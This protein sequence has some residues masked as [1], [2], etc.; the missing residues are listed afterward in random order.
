MK[1]STLAALAGAL[2]LAGG[3]AA[4][5]AVGDRDGRGWG[6]P[7]W[8]HG[9]EQGGRGMMRG[10]RGPVTKE[11]SEAQA[12]ERFARLDRN[13]D[14]VIDA[15]EIEAALNERMGA[16]RA[17]AGP[18]GQMFLRRFDENRDG[19]VTREEF[20]NYLKKRF[21][22]ADLNNDGKIT[23]DDL[24][25]MLRGRN[26]LAG[27]GSG[28]G[29]GRGRG[30]RGGEMGMQWLRGADANKDG[31]ITQDEALA[32]GL[33]RF[34]QLDRNKDGVVDQADFDA[35]RKEMVDYRVKR[36]IHRYGADKDG[37]V[38]RDQF[39]KEAADRFA[40][41]DLD[42]DGRIGPGEMG[43]G[44]GRRGRG[45]GDSGDTMG[46]RRGPGM[47]G[48]GMMGPGMM[49]PGMG[50]MGPGGQGRN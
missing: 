11:E 18:R 27:D 14:G 36:F 41:R 2:L 1:K 48:P 22:Q 46:P 44:Y 26:V 5:A 34:D 37:K 50:G 20:T 45:P 43:G 49:G 3:V 15:A 9:G 31:V 8:H 28:M 10:A 33:K 6:G 16:A 21:A 40:M 47:G 24:P 29:M 19:K 17:G 39:F 25:P 32:A 38:T 7:G 12:R 13:S 35:L 30:G 23:D 42:N 4:I